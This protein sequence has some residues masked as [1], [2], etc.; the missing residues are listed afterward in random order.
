MSEKKRIIAIIPARSG[1]KGLADKNIRE[2]NDKPLLSYTIE[3]A[4]K[5]GLFETVHV[6]T[7]SK[8]YAEI[9]R[10]YGADEPF[11]R[12]KRNAGDESSSWEVVREVLKNYKEEGQEYDIC[13]LLQPTSPLRSC[14]DIKEAYK[15]FLEKKAKSMTS[16]T[17]VEHPV[18]W[19]FKM[20][21]LCSMKEFS[22]SPFKD[23]RRQDL[24]KYYHENGAIYIVRVKDIMDPSFDF[25][26]DQCFAYVMDR[27]RSIDIDT[28]QDFIIAE[29][30]MRI[31]AEE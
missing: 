1:S 29:T 6:S 3:A 10:R 5:S 26:A 23:S 15:Q 13:F 31:H 21:D 2:L 14:N 9:A 25:Y 16:V 11:L 12:N 24:E 27:N 20:N 19:C 7:D 18:Q 30:I 22:L 4:I 17:E 28:L 8:E